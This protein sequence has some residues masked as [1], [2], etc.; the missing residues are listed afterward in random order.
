MT[1]EVPADIAVAALRAQLRHIAALVR[2]EW[3]DQSQL[4]SSVD[5]LEMELEELERHF[6]RQRAEHGGPTD[7][8]RST[9]RLVRDSEALARRAD[10]DRWAR[11]HLGKV[12]AALHALREAI[13][14]DRS[15]EGVA[16]S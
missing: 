10:V 8:G 7:L 4:A 14:S 3:Q 6:H 5:M 16:A 13:L 12:Q 2:A 11:D 9:R 1:P 15:E